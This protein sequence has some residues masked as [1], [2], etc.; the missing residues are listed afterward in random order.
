MGIR[1]AMPTDRQVFDFYVQ[2][3]RRLSPDATF[4]GAGIGRDALTV[5]RWSLEAG[6]HVRTGMEDNVRLDRDNLA[7]SNAAL[8]KQVV[9][10]VHDA[11]REVASPRVARQLLGLAG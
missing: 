4:T 9:Q 8:V 2:T 3:F 10:L 7:P 1:N 5:A 6:G 11:G